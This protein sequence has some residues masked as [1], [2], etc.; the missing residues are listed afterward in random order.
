MD[1]VH[2]LPANAILTDH[3][4]GPG[5]AR[6]LRPRGGESIVSLPEGARL[7]MS[8]EGLDML[9]AGGQGQGATLFALVVHAQGHS[10][11]RGRDLGLEL[12][13]VP[14]PVPSPAP[15]LGPA[16]TRMIRD[17]VEVVL[18]HFLV[19]GRAAVVMTFEIAGPGLRSRQRPI[20]NRPLVLQAS[21]STCLLLYVVKSSKV[22][23]KRLVACHRIIFFGQEWSMRRFSPCDDRRKKKC[24][25]I[26][27]VISNSI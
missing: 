20:P 22:H 19:G 9:V 1:V 25:R 2:R 5:R 23:E 10:L 26:L 12:G 24:L 7:A 14:A 3:V 21:S 16:L 8:V 6:A 18:A 11:Y 4:R 17:T 15:A 13:L 27:A